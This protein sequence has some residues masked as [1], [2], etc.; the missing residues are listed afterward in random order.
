MCKAAIIYLAHSYMGQHFGLGFRA[1]LDSL[2][3]LWSAA[4][5]LAHQLG[6]GCTKWPQ[7]GWLASVLCGC[8]FST[9]WLGLVHREDGLSAKRE[10]ELHEAY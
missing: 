5:Q 6:T 9:G 2:M 4:G 1:R 8:S 3:H 7:V 10:V